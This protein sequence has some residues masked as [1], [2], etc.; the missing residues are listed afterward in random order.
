MVGGIKVPPGWE[1]CI[2]MQERG[3]NKHMQRGV[4][5]REWVPSM[6]GMFIEA[7]EGLADCTC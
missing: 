1:V 3:G 7:T 5:L 6:M 4:E 2:T